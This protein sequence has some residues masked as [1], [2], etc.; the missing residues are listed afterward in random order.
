[1]D[2]VGLGSPAQL[3]WRSKA[4]TDKADARHINRRFKTTISQHLASEET[5]TPAWRPDG[6]SASADTGSSQHDNFHE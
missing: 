2:W 4:A 3:A 1:M 5:S 6:V